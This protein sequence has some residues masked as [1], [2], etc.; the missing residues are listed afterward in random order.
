MSTEELG[1]DPATLAENA[2]LRDIYRQQAFERTQEDYETLCHLNAAANSLEL[3]DKQY[4]V[5]ASRA[6]SI[7]SDIQE[8]E[9]VDTV[10]VINPNLEF[11]GTLISYSK[12]LAGRIIGAHYVRALCLAFED[13]T[14]PLYL[15]SLPEKHLLHVPVLAV[16]SI[17]K[18]TYPTL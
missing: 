3:L 8:G 7:P 13:T 6:L 15:D 17:E 14:L 12:V 1:L 10:D 11:Y 2:A 16:G 9:H 4:W 18:T 5:K